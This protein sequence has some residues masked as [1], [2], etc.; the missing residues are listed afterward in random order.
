MK[1]NPVTGAFPFLSRL[2][3]LAFGLLLLCLNARSEHVEF[4]GCYARW[5][6]GELVIGNALIERKWTIKNGLLTSTSFLDRIGNFQWLRAPGRQPA[7]FPGGQPTDANARIIFRAVAGKVSPV[8][9]PSLTVEMTVTNTAHPFACRFR[10]YPK[11]RGVEIAFDSDSMPTMRNAAVAEKNATGIETFANNKTKQWL[12]LSDSLVLAPQHLSFTQVELQDQTD[13]RSQLVFEKT[14]L[15]VQGDIQVAGNVFY[16]EDVLTGRGLVY[17]KLAPLPESRPVKS[18]WDVEYSAMDRRLSF[19]GD[20]YCSVV[21]AYSGGRAG[22]IAALQTYQRELRA[23]DP[24]RD[25][26]FLSNTWGDRSQDSRINE[27]FLNKEIA[28]GAKLGVDVIQVDDGWQRG[29]SAN[30]AFGKGAWGGFYAMDTN[31]WQVNPERFPHGLKPLVASAHKHGMKFGLWFAPDSQGGLTNWLRDADRLLALHRNQHIDYFKI[32]GVMMD[33]WQA[34]TNLNHFYDRVLR[35]TDGQVVFD[36][37]VT[38]GHRT[39]Y[40]GAVNVGPIFVE[41]RYTDYEN[42]WPHSTLRNLWQL[43]QYVDPLRLRMEFLNNARNVEKYGGNPLAPACYT[44]DTLFATVMFSNPLGWFE[45]SNLP[46]DY[47]KRVSKLVAIWKKE[48]EAIFTGTIIPIGSAPDGV[49][50]TGFVSVSENRR[51][52]RVLL[53]RELNK[54]ATWKTR[55]PLLLS[56]D[57][58]R[59]TFLAGNGSA[60]INGGQLTTSI[61]K[62]LG[63]LFLRVERKSE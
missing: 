24:Q 50:W 36:A 12:K 33:S 42:Y 52:A 44:P 61:T 20:A 49:S 22:R 31:F 17:L 23:Y 18:D 28:A 59:V 16:L 43:A 3:V 32:D 38:A 5:T 57:Q 1:S 7:P 15:P 11:S 54:D 48:R 46:A 29:R 47:V 8:S 56:D 9:A 13:H 41:N 39:G 6:T 4:Q 62:P 26:M 58:L 53:F 55:L 25:G 30:S 45:D 21:L 19:A 63:Y 2:T 37:D 60:N 35:A 10:I 51:S 40:F 27:N 14:W 34:E